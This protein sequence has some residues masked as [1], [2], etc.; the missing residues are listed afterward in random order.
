LRIN[1]DDTVTP[2]EKR[3]RFR[4]LLAGQSCV[5]PGYLL[6]AIVTDNGPFRTGRKKMIRFCAVWTAVALATAVVLAPASSVAQDNKATLAQGKTRGECHKAALKVYPD[7][8]SAE[9]QAAMA[10]CMAGQ[11]I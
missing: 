3:Q 10:R 7:Y 9:H 8:R 5:N 11:K 6:L 1:Q 4:A 2:I